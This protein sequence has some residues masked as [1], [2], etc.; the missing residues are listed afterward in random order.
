MLFAELLVESCIIASGLDSCPVPSC[1]ARRGLASKQQHWQLSKESLVIVPE[2]YMS[3]CCDVRK[4]CLAKSWPFLD[5]SLLAVFSRRSWRRS[6]HRPKLISLLVIN[7]CNPGGNV[8]A[9]VQSPALSCPTSC[10]TSRWCRH[11]AGAY[12]FNPNFALGRGL[13][14]ETGT[15]PA[16]IC[17][18][19]F[20][21]SARRCGAGM[22]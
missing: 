20:H 1:D 19:Y 2:D 22:G 6:R 11:Q 9:A 3:L 4:G 18:T 10:T 8:P 12:N 5:C 7:G 16:T 15:S 21:R 14:A 17:Q 13:T